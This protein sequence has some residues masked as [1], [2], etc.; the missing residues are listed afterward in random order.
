MPFV[1]SSARDLPSAASSPAMSSGTMG[2]ELCDNVSRFVT[3]CE[4][5]RAELGTHV[6]RL[7]RKEGE[8]EALKQ[9]CFHEHWN[10]AARRLRDISAHKRI[11]CDQ[12]LKTSS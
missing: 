3:D 11:N 8:D 2:D 7:A 12:K 5:P 9:L 10:V 4:N 6:E 1:C